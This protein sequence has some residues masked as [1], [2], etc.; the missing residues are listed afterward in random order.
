[1]KIS[2]N[3]FD[4]AKLYSQE[5]VIL[6][7]NANVPAPKGAGA[8][9][10]EIW[11]GNAPRPFIDYIAKEADNTEEKYHCIGCALFAVHKKVI[12]LLIGHK[13]Y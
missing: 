1:M 8:Q 7:V 4:V 11:P 10:I 6:G 3:P 2:T 12:L 5:V 9:E 13:P